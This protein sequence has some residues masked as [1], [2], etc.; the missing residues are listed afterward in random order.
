VQSRIFEYLSRAFRPSSLSS[1]VALDPLHVVARRCVFEHRGQ[2]GYILPGRDHEKHSRAIHSLLRCHSTQKVAS[3]A[4]LP[5]LAFRG[6]E[7]R[8]PRHN[9]GSFWRHI[10]STVRSSG[11]QSSPLEY[12]GGMQQCHTRRAVIRWSQGRTAGSPMQ[13]TQ[14]A[15]RATASRTVAPMPS[16]RYPRHPARLH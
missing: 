6:R 8:C 10:F 14:R 2:V 11:R 3:G 15:I 5:Q 1:F 9:G 7:V 16:P 13:S 12:A 4:P